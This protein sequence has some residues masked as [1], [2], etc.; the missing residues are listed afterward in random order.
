MTQTSADTI[1]LVSLALLSFY[2][3]MPNEYAITELALRRS[4]NGSGELQFRF[5]FGMHER[6]VCR[7]CVCVFAVCTLVSLWLVGCDVSGECRGV[8]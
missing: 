6:L 1:N 7:A 5:Q 4:G 8:E 3:E 2:A